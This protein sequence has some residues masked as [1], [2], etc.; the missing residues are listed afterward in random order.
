MANLRLHPSLPKFYLYEDKD[1]WHRCDKGTTDTLNKAVMM[2]RQAPTEGKAFYP[3]WGEPKDPKQTVVAWRIAPNGYRVVRYFWRL[4]T[5]SKA[6]GRCKMV[7]DTNC[8]H[9]VP[10]TL[11]Y[12]P[13]TQMWVLANGGDAV[14]AGLAKI[15]DSKT[16]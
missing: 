3:Q 14:S 7:D 10:Y 12:D 1:G 16:Y 11:K 5:H 6:C 4:E 8:A 15:L 2:G 13:T 9:I